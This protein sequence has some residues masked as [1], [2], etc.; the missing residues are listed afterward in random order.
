LHR[1]VSFDSFDKN[2]SP[3]HLVAT[4]LIKGFPITRRDYHQRPARCIA[5]IS[6]FLLLANVSRDAHYILHHG[7]RILED[8]SVNLLVDVTDT[9][10]ALIVGG[11]VCLVDVADF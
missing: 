5:S 8:V 2:K 6:S 4:I 1:F 11:R 9:R 3:P 10:A 7:G